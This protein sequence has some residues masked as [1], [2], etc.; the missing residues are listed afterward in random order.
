MLSAQL[1]QDLTNPWLRGILA[2]VAVTVSVN[3]AF[4]TYAFIFPPN[5]VVKDYYERSKNYFHDAQIRHDEL[6]TAWRLQLLV[7]DQLSVNDAQTCRLYVMDHQGQPVRS[8]NVTLAAYRPD[9]A[10]DDFKV[11]LKLVDTG[12]FAASVNFPLPGN[13]DVIAR[14]D[15]DGQHFDT[16]QR[17]FVQK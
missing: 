7:P 17:I 8:G 1:K 4:I 13:W 3:I 9:N 6:P 5:L 16:A 2:V 15:A 10:E 14:I 11:E 12:T